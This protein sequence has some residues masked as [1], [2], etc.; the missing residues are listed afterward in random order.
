[1]KTIITILCLLAVACQADT[2]H[3]AIDS[4]AT[5]RIFKPGKTMVRVEVPV[6]V[7]P[8]DKLDVQFLPDRVV[9]TPKAYD[10]NLWS[11][12]EYDLST[13]L[14]TNW[15]AIENGAREVGLIIEETAATIVHKG[16]TNRFVLE[17]REI[18]TTGP[19]KVEITWMMTNVV[20]GLGVITFDDFGGGPAITIGK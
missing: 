20:S 3:I 5:I 19:R 4:S 7:K 11:P 14:K 16:K 15:T 12:L 17:S 13:D 8:A 9:I 2:N 18:G 10:V 1:M 6:I